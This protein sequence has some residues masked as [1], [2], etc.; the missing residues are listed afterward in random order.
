MGKWSGT[1]IAGWLAINNSTAGVNVINAAGTNLGGLGNAE[2]D[3]DCESG[4]KGAAGTVQAADL[5]PSSTGK[6][7]IVP[8]FGGTATDVQ[9][10]RFIR[11][12]VGEDG[13]AKGIQLP[14][15]HFAGYATVVR[16]YIMPTQA[17]AYEVPHKFAIRDA[18]NRALTRAYQAGG[19]VPV[20]LAYDAARDDDA[21]GYKG[22]KKIVELTLAFTA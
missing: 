22:I 6:P 8:Q 19:T 12:K 9:Q 14:A 21:S 13:M 20:T 5:N 10:P 15:V 3:F 1:E 7:G 2:C 18:L 17:F 4:W 11:I 16:G